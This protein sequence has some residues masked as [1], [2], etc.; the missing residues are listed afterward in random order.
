MTES[1]FVET[2]YCTACEWEGTMDQL[3]ERNGQKCCPNCMSAD[4]WAIV[5]D[6][7]QEEAA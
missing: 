1:E 2:V 3:V 6:E 7:D 5:E 4:E